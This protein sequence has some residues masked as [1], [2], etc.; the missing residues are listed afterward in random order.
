MVDCSPELPDQARCSQTSTSEMS[1]KGLDDDRWSQMQGYDR[2]K[3]RKKETPYCSRRVT[4][5]CWL[6]K[7]LQTFWTMSSTLEGQL[8]QEEIY[9]STSPYSIIQMSVLVIKE[10]LW[11]DPTAIIPGHFGWPQI[12][13]TLEK[14]VS[15]WNQKVY[16][17]QSQS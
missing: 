5:C 17:I 16:M 10:N 15:K 12:C 4:V 7:N 2:D 3:G 13:I 11:S 8:K 6:L 14:N 1:Q 9:R